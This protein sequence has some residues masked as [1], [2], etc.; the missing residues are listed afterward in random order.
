MVNGLWRNVKPVGDLRVGQVFG[1]QIQDFPLAARESEGISAG[2]LA[3]FAGQI[4]NPVGLE[5]R[6]QRQRRRAGED[7]EV[8]DWIAA[9]YALHIAGDW[10]GAAAAWEALGC[11]YEQARA[12][13]DGDLE[14]RRQALAIFEHLGARPAAQALR[15][16]LEADGVANLPRKPRQATRANPF[17]LTRRQGEILDLL[18]ENLTN[19]EIADRLH[20]SPKT[21]DHHVSAVL[22]KLNVAT[23]REAA[24]LARRFPADSP[25]K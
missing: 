19:A 11:P 4:R 3:G 8:P 25:E 20:I 18:T 16:Q 12:L 24:E 13:A 22:A 1:Q 5:L 21:V 10:Q 9:P 2:R 17:G 23:R 14:A 15:A 6:P 7:L